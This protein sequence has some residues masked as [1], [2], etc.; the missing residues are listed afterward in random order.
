MTII[1]QVKQIGNREYRIEQ[2]ETVDTRA[3]RWEVVS[4]PINAKTGKGWQ[5][6]KRHTKFLKTAEEALKVFYELVGEDDGFDLDLGEWEPHPE[7]PDASKIDAELIRNRR[8]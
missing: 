1:E 5:A 7:D 3:T 2:F 8:G 6:T 4:Q